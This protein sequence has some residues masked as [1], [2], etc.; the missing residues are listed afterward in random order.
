MFYARF[1]LPLC[2]SYIWL[3]TLYIIEKME[4][5][6]VSARKYRPDTF[7]S[8]VAQKSLT[9]TLKNAIHSGRLAHAYLFCGPRGVGKTTCAR[10][11][12]KTINCTNPTENGEPCN[13]CESC[14]SFNQ[15]RS[16]SIYELD[17]ASNN[18]V[19][20][21]R[22]LNEQVRIPP[23][24]G[25]YKVYIIDEVHML[26]TSAFNA[27][28]KTLEEPPAHAIFILATTE[29]HKVIPTI[30]SRCQIYDFSRIEAADIIAHLKGIAEK[31]GIHCDY[32]ALRI[33]A[34]KSDGCMRDALS[35]FDQMASFTQGDLTYTKVIE[36]LNVLDYE[37]YFRLTDYIIEK[38]TAQCL[39]LFND[40]LNKGF[41]GNIFIEGAASHFRDLLVNS[42]D[43]T[44]ELFEGSTDLRNRYTEQAKRC[45]PKML[46]NAIRLCSNCSMNYRTSRNKRLQVELTLI[47]LSQMGESDSD[48]GGGLRPKILKPIFNKIA[49]QTPQA[50][51]AQAT[52]APQTAQNIQATNNT[53]TLPQQSVAPAS[54]VSQRPAAPA[55][56]I[57]GR[58]A[59][60]RS[61]GEGG[62]TLGRM[63]QKSR[64]VI[65]TGT[66]STTPPAKEETRVER[67]EPTAPSN[68]QI[69]I[70][71]AMLAQA[72]TSF[73]LLLPENER[74]LADR[75]K[76]M[77][78]KVESQNSFIISVD[79]QMA[80]DL[81]TREEKRICEG[82]SSFLGDTT[83]KMRVVVN[84]VVVER[85]T[86]DKS[87]QYALL[88]EKNPL[89]EKLRKELNLEV[90]R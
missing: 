14:Q 63:F 87:K 74:A 13:Q 76:I 33:I 64:T 75:M 86:S 70:T 21:I 85:H 35:L 17:A 59:E 65:E 69:I 25:K 54:T 90:S 72:W 4:N 31:E 12:A 49:N 79:N 45:T 58:P 89:V 46:F 60:L 6:I 77:V 24:V 48:D 37:Y 40:V 78:P 18:S 5:Y 27:F 23:Q 57:Q 34:Q 2:E 36:S 61:R 22:S 44:A 42:D 84:K 3:F 19:D 11:F 26:T 47:E 51:A 29:K 15:Q 71:D 20:D 53:Q 43:A 83:M 55:P 50:Q 62:G 81:F 39:L 38:K 16:Y 73:A 56:T 1:A 68:A 9:T 52:Q 30:L 41:E 88:V 80:A 32:E 82:M 67:P 28:L 66:Q 8:V 10:I 7:E